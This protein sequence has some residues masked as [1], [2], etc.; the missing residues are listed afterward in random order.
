MTG[1]FSKTVLVK[2]VAALE[3]PSNAPSKYGAKP[4]A[5]AFAGATPSFTQNKLSPKSLSP[6]SPL[7]RKGSQRGESLSESLSPCVSRA[8]IVTSRAPALEAALE[9]AQKSHGTDSFQFIVGWNFE[10]APSNQREASLA[11]FVLVQHSPVAVIW[12]SLCLMRL[13][14]SIGEPVALP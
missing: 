7:E 6:L 11:Q 2:V 12:P 4:F 10:G 3:T 14:R 5:G 1:C 13:N 8:L 9:K